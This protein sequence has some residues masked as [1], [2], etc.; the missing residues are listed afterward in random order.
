MAR[1]FALQE[2]AQKLDQ[3]CWKIEFN[4]TNHMRLV[5]YF[6]T[7]LLS[8]GSAELCNQHTMGETNCVPL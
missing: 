7:G 1:F 4:F 3:S 2:S 5:L 6:S 8:P